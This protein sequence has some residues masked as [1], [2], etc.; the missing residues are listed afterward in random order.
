LPHSAGRDER[1]ETHL[2]QV[3]GLYGL[4]F[5]DSS[6]VLDKVKRKTVYLILGDHVRQVN[7]DEAD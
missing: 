4:K 3:V 6:I 1:D 5:R 7:P 2:S